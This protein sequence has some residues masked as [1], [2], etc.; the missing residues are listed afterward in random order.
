MVLALELQKVERSYFTGQCMF[1]GAW[2]FGYKRKSRVRVVGSD[3][4]MIVVGNLKRVLIPRGKHIWGGG[5]WAAFLIIVAV[6]V[7]TETIASF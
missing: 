3:E 1:C 5:L 7:I 6:P 4:L 2:K